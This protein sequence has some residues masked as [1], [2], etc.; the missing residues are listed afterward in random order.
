MAA[1]G[2][3]NTNMEALHFCSTS[4]TWNPMQAAYRSADPK[5]TRYQGLLLP[6][7]SSLIGES[8]CIMFAAY[9]VC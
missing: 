4:A 7:K 3:D 5:T 6:L 8:P 2:Q 1:G 9:C